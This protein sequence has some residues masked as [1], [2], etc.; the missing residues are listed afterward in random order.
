MPVVIFERR[1][2]FLLDLPQRLAFLDPCINLVPEPLQKLAKRGKLRFATWISV[3]GHVDVNVPGFELAKAFNQMA[4]EVELADKTLKTEIVERKRA[5]EAFSKSETRF[6][7]A[8]DYAPTGNA[9]INPDGH[10]LQ[11]GLR[12]SGM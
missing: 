2:E 11:N 8:F 4:T 1:P 3:A 9:L 6:Q 10:F 7:S 5:E 12:L